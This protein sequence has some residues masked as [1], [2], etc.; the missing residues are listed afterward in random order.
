MKKRVAFSRYYIAIMLLLMYIPIMLVILYSFNVSKITSVW[1]GFTLDW[2]RELFRD[3]S[4]LE[5]LENSVILGLLSSFGAAVIGTLAAAGMARVKMK[6]AGIMEYFSIMPIMIPEIIL[7]MVFLA[8]FALLGLP[9]G[10]LTLVIAHISFCTPYVYLLVK[11][12]LAGMDK[13]F[14]EAA[15]DLG[16]G[17]LRAFYDVTLP[18]LLPAVVSGILLSF[19]MS[20]DDVIISAFVTGVDTNTLPLKIYSQVKTGI[21][22]K[23]NALCTLMFLATVLLGALSVWMGRPRKTSAAS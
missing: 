6:G 12:R 18:L 15:K 16:A 1:S 20:F 4:M 14:I 10:M 2:Y 13:S 21:T 22:P 19:A 17:E 7:G 8:F 5:A 3:R 23:T 9:F 11:A